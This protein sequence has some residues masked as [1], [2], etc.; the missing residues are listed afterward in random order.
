MH[1]G[2][3]APSF[4]NP[5]PAALPVARSDFLIEQERNGGSQAAQIEKQYLAEGRSQPFKEAVCSSLHIREAEN[6][7]VTK[8][9][10]LKSAGLRLFVPLQF[11][12]ASALTRS[13]DD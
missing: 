2:A 11:A 1:E 10:G 9:K 3:A 6:C 4:F 12:Y 7:A 5:Q 13:S 8:A